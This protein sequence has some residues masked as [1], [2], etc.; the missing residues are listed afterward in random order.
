MRGA[1][2]QGRSGSEALGPPCAA[3]CHRRAVPASERDVATGRTL[4]RPV[5]PGPEPDVT[6]AERTTAPSP[7]SPVAPG[8]TGPSTAADAARAFHAL[9]QAVEIAVVGADEPL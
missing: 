8:P 1:R 7:L 9:R 6:D 4:G 2:N 5:R 3:S